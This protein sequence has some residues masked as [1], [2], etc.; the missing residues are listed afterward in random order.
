MP[1]TLSTPRL[2][3][4]PHALADAP[5]MVRLNA[6]PEVVRYT[7][8]GPLDLPGALEVVRSLHE[9]QHPHGVARLLVERNGEPIGW[10]GLRRLVPD[11]TPDLGYR[12]LRSAWGHGYATEASIAV[13]DHGFSILSIRKVRAEADARNP[14]SIRVMQR[15][16][17]VLEEEG[18]DEEGPFVV[19]G[20]TVERWRA[21]RAAVPL[22]LD[23]NPGMR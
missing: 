17:M 12:F 14:A 5:F 23:G 16:G 20:L 9:R 1:V 19:Y 13:L 7:G 2:T 21:V 10:C 4:R 18:T 8:D 15:L 22:P 3:L 11:D 6:D